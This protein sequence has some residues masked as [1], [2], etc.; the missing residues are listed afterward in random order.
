MIFVEKH[1]PVNKGWGGGVVVK[2]EREK[3]ARVF[4]LFLSRNILSGHSFEKLYNPY[5]M[6]LGCV[7]ES[8]I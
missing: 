7:Y 4:L 3:I 2:N 6:G 1:L 5:G 8:F